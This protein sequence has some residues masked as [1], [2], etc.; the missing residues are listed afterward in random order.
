[1]W[2]EKKK[3]VLGT[4]QRM[5]GSKGTEEELDTLQNK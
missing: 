2:F 4:W 1:M 5:T 3:D